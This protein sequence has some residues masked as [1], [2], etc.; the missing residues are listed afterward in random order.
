MPHQS[1][2]YSTPP[3]KDGDLR[4]TKLALDDPRRP[5][6]ILETTEAGV[7]DPSKHFLNHVVDTVRFPNGNVGYH[8]RVKLPEG[9]MIAHVDGASGHETVALVDNY[10]HPLGRDSREL[11]SGGLDPDETARFEQASP[12]ERELLLKL[13]AIR[14]FR[15]EIGVRLGPQHV[16]RLLPGPLQGSVGYA[17]QTYNIFHGEGGA[18]TE[19]ALDDG[20]AGMLTHARYALS[21]TPEMIGREI[22]DPATSTAILAL[23]LEYGI[24]V[25][26]RLQRSSADNIVRL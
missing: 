17:D 22:V 23:A 2:E 3:L 7:P 13:A 1:P 5:I 11:P 24:R 25:K 18:P 21:D 10:R 26:S 4:F 20:E 8:H 14:E 19:Q 6:T 12:E 16:N 9:V 15:E